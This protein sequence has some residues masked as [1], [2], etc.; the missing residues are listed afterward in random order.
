M[1]PI[2]IML[3]LLAACAPEQ[4]GPR[5]LPFATVE[6]GQQSAQTERGEVVIRDAESWAELWSL[7]HAGRE[8]IPDLP[9]VDFTREIAVAAFMGQRTTGGH[10]IEIQRAVETDEEILLVVR[11]SSPPPDAMTTQVMTSPYHIIRMERTDKEIV[12]ERSADNAQVGE[13]VIDA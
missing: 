10:S 3:L 9:Q 6:Q 8:P 12:W 4:D 13:P 7:V 11:E 5:E 1:R 2:L